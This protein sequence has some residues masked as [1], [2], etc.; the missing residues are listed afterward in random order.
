MKAAEL[1]AYTVTPVLSLAVCAV[2][3]RGQELVFHRDGT[4]SDQEFGRSIADA[5]D[6]DGDGISDL[7]V[8]APRSAN[9]SGSVTLISGRT[10]E[11]LTTLTLAGGQAD[12]L[13]GYAVA[14][15]GDFD[16]DGVPDLAVGAPGHQV[17]SGLVQV[18]SGKLGSGARLLLEFGG[19]PG[20]QLGRAVA[21]VGDVENDGLPELLAGAP[22]GTDPRG[23]AP[24]YVLLVSHKSA[25]NAGGPIALAPG[26]GGGPSVTGS[27]PANLTLTLKE[28]KG[29][30]PQDRFGSALSGGLSAKGE[31]LIA[32]GAS[33][34]LAQ[35]LKAGYVEVYEAGS[36]DLQRRLEG[37]DTGDRFGTS[38]A[39]TGDLNGDGEPELLVGAPQSGP[40]ALP[41]Q[42][43]L[44]DAGALFVY[45]GG[46]L[47]RGGS[48]APQILYEV[49]GAEGGEYL[50]SSVSGIADVTGDGLP[51]FLVGVPN[52]MVDGVNSGLARVYSSAADHS[53]PPGVPNEARPVYALYGEP[54]SMPGKKEFGAAVTGV[55]D[56]R[57]LVSDP[58]GPHGYVQLYEALAPGQG[59]SVAGSLPGVHFGEGAA[60]LGDL[61]GD[62]LRDY[63]VGIPDAAS[64]GR[65]EVF[66]GADASI[67]F[68]RDGKTSGERYGAAVACAGDV[69][70]D[71]IPDVLASAPQADTANG[72][73]SG[74]VEVLSG[75]GGA[76]LGELL[77]AA[78]GDEFG[79]ALAAVGDV[80]GDGLS[81]FAVGAPRHG[82]GRVTVHVQ[83]PGPAFTVV[84]GAPQL[85]NF[86]YALSGLGDVD[87]DGL[88]E[89][90]VGAPG[91]EE[92]RGQV[93]VVRAVDGTPLHVTNMPGSLRVGFSVAALPDVEGDGWSDYVVGAPPECDD[94]HVVGLASVRSGVSG[95]EIYVIEGEPDEEF[96]YA[97]AYVGDVNLDQQPDFAVGAPG[98]ASKGPDTGRVAAYSVAAWLSPCCNPLACPPHECTPLQFEIEGAHA[99]DRFGATL[100]GLSLA[101]AG[102]GV[103]TGQFLKGAPL[104]SVSGSGSG[105]VQNSQS[106]D[107]DGDG[108]PDLQDNCV[109]TYNP[110]QEDEDNDG[111]GDACQ[112]I[113]APLGQ[114]S[115]TAGGTQA[116]QITLH[117]D[118]AGL[119]YRIRGAQK[120]DPNCP[121]DGSC[122][123][124]VP[125]DDW[126]DVDALTPPPGL[127]FHDF[128]GVLDEN[129]QAFPKLVVQPGMVDA[130][131]V[132]TTL[133]HF[134]EVTD[135]T[136][137][138]LYTAP[139]VLHLTP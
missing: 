45:S 78:A 87:G 126:M 77:G 4:G 123:P 72:A 81:D 82:P 43:E 59:L 94:C 36:G 15:V 46:S 26:A 111:V 128:V 79:R 136:G 122:P 138:V 89:L 137:A 23:P 30:K 28:F 44:G 76:L 115:V 120:V 53:Q 124:L 113:C 125:D 22:Y 68:A 11:L 51:D 131:L 95:S 70:G 86:G 25:S 97:V 85:R 109:N 19:E 93:Q 18:Y 106:L 74:R 2:P 10:G 16:L 135:S 98:A 66:S 101:C 29:K 88:P 60:V 116:I 107:T 9:S 5:G 99:G 1:A 34:G 91:D 63:A 100:A 41:A 67:L 42:G 133:Y 54:D 14:A 8:G 20:D 90:V 134:A 139:V 50:G 64:G 21:A 84:D 117:R 6:L 119:P 61:D 39:F 96:G 102:P 73:G 112:L 12:D 55:G 118:Y 132:G 129:A 37:E 56:G 32:I 108:V 40:G 57:I 127:E 3:T 80:D 92:H 35:G 110:L 33:Q 103:H 114:L 130:S 62:G 38:L 121:I 75:A 27:D 52:A 31:T 48:S 17:Q 24:G 13:F 104:A 7:I 65:V 71:G 58:G 105:S 83:I 69:D 47:L 49:C